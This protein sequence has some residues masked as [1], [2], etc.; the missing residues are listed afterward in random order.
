M[1]NDVLA[2]VLDTHQ[3]GELLIRRSHIFGQ[4]PRRSHYSR[5]RLVFTRLLGV[6]QPFDLLTV[7]MYIQSIGSASGAVYRHVDT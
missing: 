3:T 7:R 6:V 2:K 4:D 5:K 1:P